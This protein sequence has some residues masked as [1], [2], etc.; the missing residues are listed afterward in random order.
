MNL[1]KPN[2]SWKC[3]ASILINSY[4]HLL[5]F[6]HHHLLFKV[7]TFWEPHKILKNLPRG[8]D[9]SADL[10]SKLQTMR[11]IFSNYVCFS[12]FFQEEKEK[13]LCHNHCIWRASFLHELIQYIRLEFVCQ[14]MPHPKYYIWK[15]SFIC[16]L[17]QCALLDFLFQ[18]NLHHKYYIRIA[19]TFRNW[20]NMAILWFFFVMNNLMSF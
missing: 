7:W 14:K 16:E 12:N 5:W 2:K 10:L 15:A 19:S 3:A 9:K 8:F 18:K 6:Y 13:N 11:K 20:F 1:I 17:I 4:Y